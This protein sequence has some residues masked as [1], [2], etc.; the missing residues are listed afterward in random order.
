MA[1]ADSLST[2][3]DDVFG[4][5]VDMR[6]CRKCFALVPISKTEDHLDWHEQLRRAVDEADT[7]D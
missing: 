1:E 7:L 3:F 5:N 2:D 6:C 4:R